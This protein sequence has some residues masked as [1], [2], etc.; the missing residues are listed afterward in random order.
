MKSDSNARVSSRLPRWALIGWIGLVAVL[1]AAIIVA[2]FGL[3][4]LSRILFAVC[5]VVVVAL[6]LITVRS[7]GRLRDDSGS[8]ENGD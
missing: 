8:T 1:L 3:L 4:L 7:Q 6:I 5:A 2:L